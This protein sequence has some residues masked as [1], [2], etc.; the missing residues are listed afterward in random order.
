[1]L[2]FE[3]KTSISNSFFSKMAG[4]TITLHSIH[5]FMLFNCAVEVEVLMALLPIGPPLG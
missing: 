3:Y 1:M 5:I 4:K 2:Q